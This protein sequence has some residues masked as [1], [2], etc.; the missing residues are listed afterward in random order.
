MN[1]F[2]KAFHLMCA[3]V[4]SFTCIVW[5]IVVAILVFY[6]GRID[7]HLDPVKVIF[8][9][10]P[11]LVAGAGAL[12]EFSFYNDERTGKASHVDGPLV[13]SEMASTGLAL[14]T[15]RPRALGTIALTLWMLIQGLRSLSSMR[16]YSSVWLFS[17]LLPHWA[18][19]LATVAFY[20]LFAWTAVNFARAL[21][22]KEEKALMFTI[23]AVALLAP[24]GFLLPKATTPLRF[25]QT[26]LELIALLASIS[27]L[28]SLQKV[29][30]DKPYEEENL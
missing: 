2:A 6:R 23:F 7:L 21:P 3:I 16:P 8:I 5:L 17:G 10:I 4:A 24:V 27:I 9:L 28:L 13:T 12:M 22:R 20:G 29:A 18:V 25:L 11:S 26:L 30:N 14:V 1:G 15:T 19:V